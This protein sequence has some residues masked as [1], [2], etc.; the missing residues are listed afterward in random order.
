MNCHA[1]LQGIFPQGIFPTQ[2]SNPCPTSLMSPAWAVGS[3]SLAPPTGM[4]GCRLSMEGYQ[5]YQR[6]TSCS[7][8][9]VQTVGR[10][11]SSAVLQC[12]DCS[13]WSKHGSS[14][15]ST[16]PIT[17]SSLFFPVYS[18]DLAENEKC[19]SKCRGKVRDLEGSLVSAG[20]TVVTIVWT[21]QSRCA[22]QSMDCLH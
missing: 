9:P 19:T 2:G 3:L 13:R 22:P 16:V 20:Y 21:I 15:A 4:V 5:G 18:D 14:R 17:A 7:E 8:V 12:Q 6:R 11:H 10:K 1:F